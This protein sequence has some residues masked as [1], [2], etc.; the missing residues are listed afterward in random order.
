[1]WM[2]ELEY[3]A[4]SF[5]QSA[6]GCMINEYE[7]SDI[8]A[9]KCRALHHWHGYPRAYVGRARLDGQTGTL[10]G[11]MLRVRGPLRSWARS[12]QVDHSR[13]R[14]AGRDLSAHTRT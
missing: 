3:S 5:Q 14:C 13:R 6:G 4:T 9:P 12:Q 11:G 2:C 10:R 7:E 8:Y 1:M